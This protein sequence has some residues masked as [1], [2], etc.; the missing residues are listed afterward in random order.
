MDRNVYLK[1]AVGKAELAINYCS[2]GK[3]FKAF[4]ETNVQQE[5]FKM[6][7]NTG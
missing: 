7:Q 3:S 2:A 5:I 6:T 4:L 1:S